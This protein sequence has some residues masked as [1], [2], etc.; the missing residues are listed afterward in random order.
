MAK[1]SL[2]LICAVVGAVVVLLLASCES[3]IPPVVPMPD[4]EPAAANYMPLDSS[5]DMFPLFVGAR[6][7]YRNATPDIVPVIHSGDL[8]ETEVAAIARRLDTASGTP[9][10][11]FVLR[12]RQGMAPEVLSYLRRTR[13]G[14]ALY[15]IERLPYAGAPELTQFNG[16]SFINLPFEKDLAWSFSRPDTAS[17]DSV[18]LGQETVPLSA[19]VWKLLG[20]YTAIFTDAWRLKSEFGGSLADAYG[21]GIVEEWFAPG[22]GMIKRTADSLFYE[23]VQF[24]GSDEVTLLEEDSTA[25]P[26]YPPVGAVVVVQLRGAKSS[27]S[28]GYAWELKNWNEITAAGVLTPLS[29]GGESGE[30]FADLDG[31]RR[32]GTGTYVFVF[33]VRTQGQASLLFT[34]YGFGTAASAAPESIRFNLGK[35]Q[36]MNLSEGTVQ[37]LVRTTGATATFTVHYTDGDGNPPSLSQV[38][39]DGGTSRDMAFSHGRLA[40]GYYTS[41]PVPI[42][43]GLHTYCFRFS[44]E[45]STDASSLPCQLQAVFDV[46][47]LIP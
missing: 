29:E 37:T 19:T 46:G 39:I 30:F 41:G 4:E 27:A 36:P 13:D 24:R 31:A 21:Y 10:E 45:E 14:V 28:S 26:Y 2:R 15:G 18:I 47:G 40:D 1:L 33:E 38:W 44:D 25:G 3:L 11:C 23:L 16:E 12:T 42:S 43:E 35:P 6:W 17:L 5:Q 7:V 9:Y 8:I 32:V 22:V 20:P 34:R